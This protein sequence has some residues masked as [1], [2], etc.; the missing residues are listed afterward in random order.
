[1]SYCKQIV[2]IKKF[3]R[4]HLSIGNPVVHYQ[5]VVDGTEGHDVI[6]MPWWRIDGKKPKVGKYLYWGPKYFKPVL[7]VEQYFM[8]GG[9]PE[10]SYRVL[11]EMLKDK[12][13]NLPQVPGEKLGGRM[14]KILKADG[15][16][17]QIR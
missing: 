5:V 7:N 14:L 17:E 10:Y 3:R 8:G 6:M 4:K 12:V 11:D 9:L 15:T 2:S 1:M 13:V 16:L